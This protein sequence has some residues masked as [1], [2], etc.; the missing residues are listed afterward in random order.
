SVCRKLQRSELRV[1]A[2][3]DQGPAQIGGVRM[4][5]REILTAAAVIGL[6]PTA[7]AFAAAGDL[8]GAAREAY[9][10]CLPLIEMAAARDR[11]LHEKGEGQPAGLNFFK[12]TRQLTTHKNRT[13]TTPNNDTLYSS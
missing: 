11:M 9:I 10:Y 2:A 12:P 5:R 6:V 1:A 13:I 8:R 4:N 7:R 3:P